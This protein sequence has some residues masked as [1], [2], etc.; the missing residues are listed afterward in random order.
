MELLLSKL[1]V[2]KNRLSSSYITISQTEIVLQLPPTEKFAAQVMLLIPKLALVMML[3]IE[4]DHALL[5]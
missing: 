4:V 1:K 5:V 2:A 3:P